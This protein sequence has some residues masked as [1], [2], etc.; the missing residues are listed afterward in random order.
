MASQAK[1]A[2]EET[3]TTNGARSACYVLEINAKRLNPDVATGTYTLWVD[4]QQYLVARDELRQIAD[5]RVVY[6]NSILFD[7]AKVDEPIEDKLFS[8]V[9]GQG[10]KEVDSFFR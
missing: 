6:A 2:R 8:F 4:K 3:C 9:P 7:V 5:G 10:A 1:L